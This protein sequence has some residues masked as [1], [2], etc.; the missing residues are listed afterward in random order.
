M[1]PWVQGT[2]RRELSGG[3]ADVR[4]QRRLITGKYTLKPLI[5]QLEGTGGTESCVSGE[6]QTRDLP[7]MSPSTCRLSYIPAA[8]DIY[9]YTY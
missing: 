1:T 6:A 5:S 8:Y 9:R 2:F 3:G 4:H 7:I